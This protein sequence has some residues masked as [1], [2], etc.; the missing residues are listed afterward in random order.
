MK[1]ILGL[2]AFIVMSVIVFGYLSAPVWA[3]T[4]PA[5]TRDV[6]NGD[7]LDQYEHGQ[8]DLQVTIPDGRSGEGPC[9]IHVPAG[10]RLVIE[11]VSVWAN[12]PAGQ[13]AILARITDTRHFNQY[14]VLFPQGSN[15]VGRTQYIASQTI[16]Q[17][18]P[19]GESVCLELQRDSTDGEAWL[20]WGVSGYFINY[21]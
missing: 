12:L 9:S 16:R 10:K 17:R 6:D 20:T 11:H 7:R 4:R 2:L 1:R 15:V 5:L 21:P 14:L 19:P 18:V 8:L 13:K 3:Q